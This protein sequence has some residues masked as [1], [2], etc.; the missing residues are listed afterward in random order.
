VRSHQGGPAYEDDGG[1]SSD[2]GSDDEDFVDAPQEFTPGSST[3]PYPS[4][5][6]LSTSTSSTPAAHTDSEHQQ[7]QIQTQIEAQGPPKTPPVPQLHLPTSPATPT[8]LGLKTPV[9][10]KPATAGF[11]PKIFPRRTST[12]SNDSATTASAP[13]TGAGTPPVA[14][15]T[16]IATGTEKEKRKTFR[17][18]WSGSGAE[19]GARKKVDYSLGT[20]NDIVGIVM[21]EIQSADDL[22]RL[23]NSKDS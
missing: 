18:S 19:G 9:A 5:P 6:G 23:K 22:P 4:P 3:R 8:Q 15:R 17:K 13:G 21:L 7:L 12:P 2:E 20:A 11:I 10:A 1:L 14:G 16:P